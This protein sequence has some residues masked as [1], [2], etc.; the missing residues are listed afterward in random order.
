MGANVNVF[1]WCRYAT[2]RPILFIIVHELVTATKIHSHVKGPSILD[3]V[4]YWLVEQL[5]T[6]FDFLVGK[7]HIEAWEQGPIDVA[8][9]EHLHFNEHR[10]DVFVDVLQLVVDSN[11]VIAF[12]IGCGF[13][14]V[15]EGVGV[16]R[17]LIL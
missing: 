3:D 15:K 2:E 9:L 6:N 7:A 13:V 4:K 5:S 11:L 17:H 1:D 10:W 14:K 16:E 12:V 8:K